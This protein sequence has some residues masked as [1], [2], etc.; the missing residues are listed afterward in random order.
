LSHPSSLDASSTTINATRL[1]I[2]HGDPVRPDAGT[3]GLP[4]MSEQKVAQDHSCGNST[5]S[6]VPCVQG[7]HSAAEDSQG[8]GSSS[9]FS[10]CNA[11]ADRIFED[12]S[13]D[14]ATTINQPLGPPPRRPV[15]SKAPTIDV[16]SSVQT[17]ESID[18]AK[19]PEPLV[20]SIQP[21]PKRPTTGNL[22]KRLRETQEHANRLKSELQDTRVTAR[23]LQDVTN[24]LQA[25]CAALEVAAKKTL[26]VVCLDVDVGCVFLP[27]GHVVCCAAC[28]ESCTVCPCCRESITSKARA[29][30]P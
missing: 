26:C 28:G 23:T 7:S 29:Y 3:Q 4:I 12:A 24:E 10:L 18:V 25:E 27:C 11:E 21:C 1:F 20:A 15:L 30:L 16:G 6:P 9:S 14:A 8:A 5:L 2:R 17:T 22:L 19:D 13:S